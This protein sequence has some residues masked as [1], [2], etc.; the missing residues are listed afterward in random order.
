[1][2]MAAKNKNVKPCKTLSKQLAC[3]GVVGDTVGFICEQTPRGESGEQKAAPQGLRLK[4]LQDE[5]AHCT[6][7]L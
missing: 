7:Q 2:Y 4:L 6:G 5:R 1:M 3:W